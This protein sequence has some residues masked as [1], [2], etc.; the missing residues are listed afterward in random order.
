MS[1]S[2]VQTALLTIVQ[3]ASGFSA[4]NATIAD[5]GI[6]GRGISQGAI[7][8]YGGDRSERTESLNRWTFHWVLLMD[9]FF[10]GEGRFSDYN[11]TIGTT[12]QTL[13]TTILGYPQLNGTAGVTNVTLGDVSVPERFLGSGNRNWWKIT[14]P[15]QVSEKQTIPLLE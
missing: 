9:L 7:I 1:Y 4:S 12:V 13:K 3:S 15:V 14:V 8:Y 5:P 10:Q 2:T 6:L 11:S